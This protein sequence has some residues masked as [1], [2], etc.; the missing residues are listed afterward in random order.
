MID[1]RPVG[2]DYRDCDQIDKIDLN[3]EKIFAQLRGWPWE[4]AIR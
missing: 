4:P 2:R 1:R 3:G